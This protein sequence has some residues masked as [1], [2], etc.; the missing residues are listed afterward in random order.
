MQAHQVKVNPSINKSKQL[1]GFRFE[2]KGMNLKGSEI[3]RAMSGNRIILGISQNNS[4]TKL[5][6]APKSLE[7]LSSTVQLSTGMINKI[8]KDLVKQTI[9]RALDTGIGTGMG[10]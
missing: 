9:K 6:E 7:L 8:A 3:N 2:Y 1:Q 5:K 4:F 10:Y